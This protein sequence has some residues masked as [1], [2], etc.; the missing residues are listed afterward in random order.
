MIFKEYSSINEQ[1]Y[2]TKLPNGLTICV[3]PKPGFHKKFAFFATKYGGADRRFKLGEEWIDTP[4][5]VAHFLEHKMFDTENGNALEQLSQNGASPNAYT[6]N[7]M[8]A[9]Y[10]ECTDKFAENLEILLSF[11]STPYFTAESV[12][13]ERG[14]ITQEIRMYDDDSGFNLYYGLL[15]SLFKHSPLRESIAGTVESV[16]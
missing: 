4:A 9:Y 7:D 11:V 1:V 5:G 8:T 2:T 12:E 13:K 14:I 15:K 6:E 10:F 3:V 16:S